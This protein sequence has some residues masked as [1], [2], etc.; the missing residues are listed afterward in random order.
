LIEF[1]GSGF[2]LGVPEEVTDASQYILVLAPKAGFSANLTIRFEPVDSGINLNA[3]LK[4][5][6]SSLEESLEELTVISQASGMRGSINGAMLNYEWGQGT[7]RFKQKQVLLVSNSQPVRLYTL[8]TLDLV[9]NAHLSDPIFEE[10]IRSFS[11][12]DEQ[13]W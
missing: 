4:N 11:P 10:M 1:Q 13:L 9:K 7:G 2:S 5:Q 12:N 3:Y 8:T 6:I